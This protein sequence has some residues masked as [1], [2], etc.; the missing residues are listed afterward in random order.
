MSSNESVYFN[1][2]GEIV[3]KGFDGKNHYEQVIFDSRQVEAIELIIQKC[4]ERGRC[5]N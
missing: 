3:G 1:Q 4:K 2:Y 5:Q